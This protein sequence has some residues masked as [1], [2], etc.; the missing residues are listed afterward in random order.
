MSGPSN[1]TKPLQIPALLNP[2]HP[3][4]YYS[5]MEKKKAILVKPVAKLVTGVPCER[6]LWQDCSK[7]QECQAASISGVTVIV[8]T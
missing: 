8:P 1:L 2:Y 6:D 3:Y 4:P 7:K 5:V